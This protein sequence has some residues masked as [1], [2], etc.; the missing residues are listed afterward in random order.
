MLAL[1]N[2]DFSLS[3]NAAAKIKKSRNTVRKYT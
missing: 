3:K 1:A 2:I